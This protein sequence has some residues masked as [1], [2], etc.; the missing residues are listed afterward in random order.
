M[1]RFNKTD[2]E[3][4]R[5][6]LLGAEY[7]SHEANDSAD[8]MH[9]LL[10][11][12]YSPMTFTITRLSRC[13]IKLGVEDPLPRPQ[14][15]FA[16]GNRHYDLMMDQQRFEMRVAV[17]FTRVMMFVILAKRRQMFQPLIDVLD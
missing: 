17:V 1:H 12:H 3:V 16:A 10:V 8:L 9:P 6:L 7:A 4:A 11:L 14:I 2:G 5:A 15:E 13:P